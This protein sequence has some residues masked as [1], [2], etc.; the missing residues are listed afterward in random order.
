KIPSAAF[1]KYNEE[2]GYRPEDIKALQDWHQNARQG[3]YEFAVKSG[4]SN[5]QAL[6]AYAAIDKQYQQKLRDY[7]ES[8]GFTLEAGN[9]TR[10][11]MPQ[12][13]RKNGPFLKPVALVPD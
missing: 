3:A 6:A 11:D 1:Q 8:R 7:L 5:D 4:K 12:V 13:V 2:Y 9:V 10:I